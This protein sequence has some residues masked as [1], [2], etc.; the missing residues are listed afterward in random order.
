[1]VHGRISLDDLEE[2]LGI[3]M[4]SEEVDTLGGFLYNLIGK[5]PE[6]G[7]E[8][9]HGGILFRINRLEGQRIA[10]VNVILPSGPKDVK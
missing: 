4:P 9:E 1:M 2:S 6:E 8:I 5:V 7:E 3:A 10:D